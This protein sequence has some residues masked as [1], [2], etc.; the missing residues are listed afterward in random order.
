MIV[1]GNKVDMSDTDRA[2]SWDEG[3]ALAEEF[4]AVFIEVSVSSE[5]RIICCV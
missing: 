1:V 3:A 2:V 4:G 5:Q